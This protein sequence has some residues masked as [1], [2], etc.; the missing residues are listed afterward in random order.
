MTSL[1]T[2]A[3]GSTITRVYFAVP[4]LYTS[5]V[6]FTSWDDAVE[7]ARSRHVDVHSQISHYLRGWMHPD[8]I[9]ETA[10]AQVRI[11][12]R[13]VITAEDGGQLDTVIESYG[14]VSKLRT[15]KEVS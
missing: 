12:L 13:W 1:R 2:I 10:N 4:D 5:G 15:S 7:Y 11:D 8:R 14:N 6:E 9:E 3:V